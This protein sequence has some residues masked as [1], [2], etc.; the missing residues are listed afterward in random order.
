MNEK[1]RDKDNILY[2]K[3]RGKTKTNDTLNGLWREILDG[4]DIGPVAWERKMTAFMSN[5]RLML[6]FRGLNRNSVRGNLRKALLNSKRLTFR[7]FERG[8]LFLG[9]KGAR[10]IVVLEW[11]NNQETVHERRINLEQVTITK[12]DLSDDPEDDSDEGI[13]IEEIPMLSEEEFGRAFSRDFDDI[14]KD[15]L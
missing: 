7:Q 13:E 12:A 6:A 15:L 1:D 4:M 2:D 9:V 10:F 8:L 14:K 5:A 11:H 3:H